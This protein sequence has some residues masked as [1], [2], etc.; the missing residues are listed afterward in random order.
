ME[1]SSREIFLRESLFG[2]RESPGK[3]KLIAFKPDQEINNKYKII[4]VNHI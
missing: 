3:E 2:L 1:T 4:L